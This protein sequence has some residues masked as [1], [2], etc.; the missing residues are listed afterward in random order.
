[1]AT[2]NGKTS[3]IPAADRVLEAYPNAVKLKLEKRKRE[4]RQTFSG[5]INGNAASLVFEELKLWQVGELTVS[6]NGGDA[7]LHRK[8]AQVAN[9][10]TQFGNIRF[11]F[12]EKNGRFRLMTPTDNSH[13]RVGFD[14]SRDNGGYWSLIGT[15]S[16]DT[17]VVK[18]GEVTLNLDGFDQRLPPDWEGVVLHEFGHALG[19]FHEHQSPSVDCAFNWELVYEAYAEQYEWTES[20]VDD[21]LKQ[22]RRGDFTS[23]SQ[24]DKHSIMHYAFPS[25]M[26]I[27]GEN[28]PCFTT[29]N[30][31]L[32]QTDKE[33]MA[34]A[35][36]F[37]QDE[38]INRGMKTINNLNAIVKQDGLTEVTRKRY[39]NYLDFV[40]THPV[41]RPQITE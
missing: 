36:P 17:R 19:F 3:K 5:P 9:T 30:T 38:I 12:G 33:W 1:M 34:K 20:Q 28:S 26:F 21:N 7:A 22:I 40:K 6:F 39:Q 8:I 14:T 25:W 4:E 32:S 18:P 15:D 24:H 29:K 41:L 31:T 10:W 35:Y 11:D 27:D 37:D 2:N 16:Q 23:F 13:I